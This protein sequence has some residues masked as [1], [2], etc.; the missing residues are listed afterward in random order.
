[1]GLSPSIDPLEV[2][3]DGGI[4]EPFHT[5]FLSAVVSPHASND[6]LAA[7]MDLPK[8]QERSLGVDNPAQ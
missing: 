3:G 4:I 7:P 8:V 1:M 2:R 5:T 6:R